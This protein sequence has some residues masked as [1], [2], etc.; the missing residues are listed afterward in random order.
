MSLVEAVNQVR[1][2]GETVCLFSLL[3][4]VNSKTELCNNYC[5]K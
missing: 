3:L 5:V 2:N 4:N 1:I